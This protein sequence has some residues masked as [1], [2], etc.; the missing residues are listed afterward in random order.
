MPQKENVKIESRSTWEDTEDIRLMY[1]AGLFDVWYDDK[2]D[3][4]FSFTVLT[5]ESDDVFAWLHHRTPAILE[6]QEQIDIW[7]NH[8]KYPKD[9]AM[10]VIKH[11][12][13]IIWHQVSTSVNNS[14]FKAES[15]KFPIK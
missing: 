14:R 10:E 13:E 3:S 12:K 11:P 9:V 15:C 7:L 4:V 6:T 8:Q 1:M 5:F 2:G